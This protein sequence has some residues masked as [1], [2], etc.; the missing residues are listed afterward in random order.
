MMSAVSCGGVSPGQNIT[1]YLPGEA[2]RAEVLGVREDG[3]ATVKLLGIAMNKDHHLRT[4]DTVECRLVRS[5]LG[6]R[7]EPVPRGAPS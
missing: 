1:V 6:Q 3:G 4:G 5:A 7:W 2:M